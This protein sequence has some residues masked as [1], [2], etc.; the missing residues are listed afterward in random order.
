MLRF[1]GASL[2]YLDR[3]RLIVIDVHSLTDRIRA[4]RQEAQSRTSMAKFGDIPD[5][6]PPVTE[7]QLHDAEARLGFQLPKFLRTLYLE[8][9]NGGFGPGYG[10]W[11]LPGGYPT[12]L[13]MAMPDSNI[14]DSYINDVE[15]AVE[16][17]LGDQG[18][19]LVIC[20][21]GCCNGSAVDCSTADGKM[22]FLRD[23]ASEVAENLT[24]IQWMEDWANGVDL[25]K[26]AYE[27]DT[28]SE[29][30]R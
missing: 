27:S 4:R 14:I 11:G 17:A 7:R 24:F 16:E 9:G 10:L 3:Q 29:L 26:R 8:V 12:T 18:Q 20:D 22:I 5:L 30:D 2:C 28:R 6:Y 19:I 25:W 21:W 13:P 15:L 1:V 23:D